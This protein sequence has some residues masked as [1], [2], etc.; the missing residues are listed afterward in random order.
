MLLKA[1]D[2]SAM[3]LGCA[4]SRPSL[5]L[6]E[7]P[8]RAQGYYTQQASGYVQQQ[9]GYAQ[10][11][12]PQHSQS[13]QHEQRYTQQHQAQSY[14]QQQ[15]QY[16]HTEAPASYSQPLAQHPGAGRGLPAYQQSDARGEPASART[17][18]A[19]TVEPVAGHALGNHGVQRSAVPLVASSLGKGVEAVGEG[20]W[21]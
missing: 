21:E 20:E 12:H 3:L 6:L 9:Q 10:P 19:Q 15:Q 2:I 13:Y 17:M 14:Q 5:R 1:H 18:Y 11:Q 4:T 16:S 7:P 8:Q